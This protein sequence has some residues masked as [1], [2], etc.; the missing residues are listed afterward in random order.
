MLLIAIRLVYAVTSLMLD[1]DSP[2]AE[3]L[4]SLAVKVCL[5]VVPEMLAVVI[6]LNVGIATRNIRHL[7]KVE[8][9]HNMQNRKANV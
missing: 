9:A 8:P 4:R 6:L 5:S 3:F 2:H 7:H 1:L